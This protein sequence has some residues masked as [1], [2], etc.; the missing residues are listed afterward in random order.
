[1]RK[2]AFIPLIAVS[3]SL[4][5]CKESQKDE[6]TEVSINLN[7]DEDG[8]SSG[9]SSSLSIDAD[10]FKMDIEIPDIEIDTGMDKDNNLY[11]GSKITGMDIDANSKNGDDN[12]RVELRFTSPASPAKVSEWMA[13][14]IT[15]EG[16]KAVVNGNKIDGTT[17]D[18]NVFTVT[19]DGSGGST[20]GVMNIDA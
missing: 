7:N 4:A 9:D 3:L 8:S 17:D 5:A 15:E 19:L 18:G 1:M 10:G 16:G 20:K 6:E 11:P 14:K 2:L 13:K 12:A